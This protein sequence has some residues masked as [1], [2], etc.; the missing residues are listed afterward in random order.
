MFFVNSFLITGTSSGLGKFLHEKLGGISLNRQTS[1]DVL[2]EIKKGRVE[3]IIHCAFNSDQ[4]PKDVDQYYQDNVLLTAKVTKIP[5]KKFIFIS[6]VD[7]YPKNASKHTEE[8]ILDVDKPDGLYAKT[9]LLSEYLVKKN[10]SNFLILRCTALLGKYAKKNS[11]VKIIKDDKPTLTL[12]GKSVFN[13]ILHADVLAFTKLSIKNDLMGIYN[14]ASSKNITLKQVAYL[15]K[16]KVT[17]GDYIYNV[18]NID[19][20]KAAAIFRAFKKT[21]QKVIEEFKASTTN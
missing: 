17:F 10:C 16:K 18:G 1:K 8:E 3:V 7:V 20:R 5:H 15:V 13:Y 6:S 4:N 19:N 2:A 14:L 21:S 12:S 11:L 9:K